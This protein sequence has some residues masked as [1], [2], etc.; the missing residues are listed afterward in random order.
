MPALLPVLSLLGLFLDF[1]LLRRA[2][3]LGSGQGESSSLRNDVRFVFLEACAVWGVLLL[4]ITEGLSLFRWIG[5]GGIAGAWCG[6]LLITGWLAWRAWRKERRDLRSQEDAKRGRKP[7]R[8][9]AAR[10]KSDTCLSSLLV[11]DRILLAG[12]TLIVLTIGMTA[13]VAPPNTWDAM[14][15]HMARVV[16]WIQDKNVAYYPTHIE[17]QLHSPPW[18]EYAIL[19]L[20]ILSGGDRL[21]NMVQWFSMVGS[22][23]G[24]SLLARQFGAG[25]RGQ[26]LTAALCATLP[27]GI[28]QG[29][30]TQNDYVLAFWM[31]CLANA[32]VLLAREGAEGNRRFLILVGCSIGL[33]TLTK[34]T[35]YLFIPPL[36]GWFVVARIRSCRSLASLGRGILIPLCVMAAIPIAI[37][38]GF[39]TRN[40]AM[41]GSLLGP[42]TVAP[43]GRGRYTNDVISPGS[44]LSNVVRNAGLHLG[45]KI[46]LVDRPIEAAIHGVHS[47][48]GIDISDPRTT[49]EGTQFRLGGSA[50]Y[51]DSCGNTWHFYLLLFALAVWAGW[52]RLRK[53]MRVGG[54]VAAVL[55]G[56]MIFCG[57][58]RWQPWHS[59]LH[60]PLFVL[61]MPIV[62]V[63]LGEI[64][65]RWAA[66]AIGLLLLVQVLNPLLRDERHPLVGACNIFNTDRASLYFLADQSDGIAYAGAVQDVMGRSCAEL[67][68]VTGADGLEYPLWALLK[69]AGA[70]PFRIEHVMVENRSA[71]AAQFPRFSDFSPK[72]LL[73][74]LPRGAVAPARVGAYALEASFGAVHVY[75]R[76]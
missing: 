10:G 57:Y 56:A 61:A 38:S 5:F 66:W 4:A 14:T 59:R 63:A 21:A 32:L 9:A 44:I 28:L 36:V 65:W 64:R 26:T 60:M 16:H 48:L 34:A 73:A 45:T 11:F 3:R 31:V 19:H 50:I 39:Y 40:L 6:V 68:L 33:A 42:S 75:A 74:A 47:I 35:A 15:Y 30:S 27:M 49:W 25:A 1:Y 13:L 17:R 62:G 58:L 2:T 24:V 12:V 7:G 18:A 76:E 46:Q 70:G 51:E 20:Q 8:G 55:L 37:N 22:I 23:A 41:Y 72:V 43:D 67:G 53:K 54:Y 29:S 71:K 69:I 52:G